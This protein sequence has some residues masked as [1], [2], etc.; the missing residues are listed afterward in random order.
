MRTSGFVLPLALLMLL[1]ACSDSVTP[2]DPQAQEPNDHP[3]S[4]TLEADRL[5]GEAAFDVTLHARVSDPDGNRLTYAWR[6][7]GEPLSEPSFSRVCA[8]TSKG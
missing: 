2:T 6:V 4:V 7:N 3:L 1:V 8:S 5:T